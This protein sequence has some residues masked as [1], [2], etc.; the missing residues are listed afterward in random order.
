MQFEEDVYVPDEVMDWQPT[1]QMP[2]PE[3]AH[4]NPKWISMAELDPG[5]LGCIT[6]YR[7]IWEWC[8]GRGPFT[9]PEGWGVLLPEDP[10][11]TVNMHY[12]KNPGENTA[13]SD[14]TRAAFKFYEEGDVIDH[15][16]E[17]NFCHIEVGQFRPGIQTT[18]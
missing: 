6:L 17:T 2:V 4:E 7:V 3:G 9:Y 18:K 15:V 14:L 8:T 11:I 12:H 16:V 1:I 10:F 13:V 5:G